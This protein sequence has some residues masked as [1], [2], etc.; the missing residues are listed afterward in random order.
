MSITRRLCPACRR[1]PLPDPRKTRKTKCH[2]CDK[3]RERAN[4]PMRA[5]YCALRDHAR[6]RGIVFTI[7]FEEFETFALQCDYINSKGPFAHSLTV[8]RDD[9]RLGYIPGN[10]KPMTRAE[11]SRKHMRRDQ[12]RMECGMAWQGRYR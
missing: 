8:D 4:N 7:G 3:R 5:A 1:R 12:V 6:A 10:I 11:N 9:N 2:C